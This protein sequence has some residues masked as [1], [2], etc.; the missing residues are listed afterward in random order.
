MPNKLIMNN[1]RK[2]RLKTPSRI[3]CCLI[4]ESGYHNRIDG[5]FGFSISDPYWEVEITRNTQNAFRGPLDEDFR[6]LGTELINVIDKLYGTG[7]YEVNITKKVDPHIG[8]GSKTGFLMTILSGIQKLNDLELDLKEV[9]TLIKRGGTSGI[10]IHT[11]KTGGFTIDVGRKF[12]LEK[13]H[14]SPSRHSSATP[15]KALLNINLHGWKIILF[16]IEGKTIHGDN[17]MNIF[18]KHCPVPDNETAAI[19][20]ITF[21]RILPSLLELDNKELNRG[22]IEIQDLGFKKIE[23]QYQNLATKKFR[24]LWAERFPDI[25]LGLSSFGPTT[26]CVVPNEMSELI[27]TEVKK[28]IGLNLTIIETTIDNDGSTII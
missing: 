12:P 18:K 19:G 9:S 24:R 5:G 25:A 2:I 10:G 20:N 4:N 22:L 11:F 28:Y 8:L 15:P 13:S 27:I 23:W 21:F 16:C 17:E 6:N 1:M 3:H 14:F 7:C 26:Y